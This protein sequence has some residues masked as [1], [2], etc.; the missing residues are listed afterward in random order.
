MIIQ[1][2]YY[3]TKFYKIFIFQRQYNCIIVILIRKF[4]FIYVI[5]E[6]KKFEIFKCFLYEK[7]RYVTYLFL[8]YYY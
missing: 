2:N 1:Q 6:I 7:K 5:P 4:A 8:F 3:A